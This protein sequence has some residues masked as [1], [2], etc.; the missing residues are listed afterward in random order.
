M[1]KSMKKILGTHTVYVHT[2]QY[3][4]KGTRK[5][6]RKI[7][8]KWQKTHAMDRKIHAEREGKNELRLVGD[9][10]INHVCAVYEMILETIAQFISAFS[11]LFLLISIFFSLLVRPAMN[12]CIYTTKHYY[13]CTYTH[14]CIWVMYE[15]KG[16]KS[17]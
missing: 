5:R 8:E 13:Y 10:W 3:E 12:Y 4:E 2:W 15:K 6:E 1:R 16:G 11:S 9:E 14:V 7:K 17:S